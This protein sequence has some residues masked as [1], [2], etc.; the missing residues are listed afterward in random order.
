MVKKIKAIDIATDST[1]TEP[2]LEE[3]EPIKEEPIVEPPNDVIETAKIETPKN[4]EDDL[5]GSSSLDKVTKLG[6]QCLTS[7][8][9]DDGQPSSSPETKEK[10]K[11]TRKMITCPDC[12]KTMLEKNF[13]YQ[14]I[15]VCCKVKKPKPIEDVIKEKR[16]KA[17]KPDHKPEPVTLE[18][19]KTVTQ[20][21]DYLELRR[22]QYNNQVKEQQQ[23]VEILISKAF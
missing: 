12:N 21:V 7:N 18:V 13:R 19:V 6:H 17:N 20:P 15:N 4:N 3:P 23:V 5:S 22:Q 10:P 16:E 11:P 14:H 1:I 8:N 2:T 9:K